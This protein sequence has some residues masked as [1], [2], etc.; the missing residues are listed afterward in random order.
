MFKPQLRE[1]PFVA[2]SE[3]ALRAELI[4]KDLDGLIRE[5]ALDKANGLTGKAV[6]HPDQVAAVHALSVVT[7]E[8]YS[9]AIDIL[10]T[11]CAGGVT[12]SAYR[13]KM[14]ESKPHAAWAGPDRRPR[15]GVRGGAGRH[16]LRRPAGRGPEP[17][18][19]HR[20]SAG[21]PGR[22]GIERAT[23]QARS[24]LATAAER[25]GQPRRTWSD[26][27]AADRLGARLVE[28]G[29]DAPIAA[30]DLLEL[31]VRRNPRRAHLLVSR[32]LGKHLPADPVLVYGSS[33]L[34]G[35]QVADALLGRDSGIAEAGGR[36]L[37]AALAGRAAAASRLV[38][39]CE[40][41]AAGA[42]AGAVVLGFAETATA[43]GHGVADSLSARYLHS[44]RRWGGGRTAAGR[45]QEEH[46]H[47]TEP[48]AAAGRSETA[49]LG[50]PAG[51][52]RRRAVH[53]PYRAEHHPGAAAGPAVPRPLPDRRPGGSALGRGP[54]SLRRA[55]R[56][57][58][59]PDRGGRI[60][61]RSA[62][63]A[64]GRAGAGELRWLPRAVRWPPRGTGRCRF[65]RLRCCEPD[66]S[67]RCCT[68]RPASARVAGT[69]SSRP[70]AARWSRPPAGWRPSSHR[71][72]D[73][74]C[75]CSASR[76]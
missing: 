74:G 11:R 38:D 76:S 52:G 30:A 9:D 40:R 33:R 48:P 63:A 53:R 4:A 15:R 25:T 44:T 64:T 22:V 27:W 56:R 50:R 57:V 20:S 14:N 19:E 13:N 3:R 72:S 61:H 43:L 2:H 41:H 71:G 49:R 16:L 18:S 23:S 10:G 32:V 65:G 68:G 7:H 66:R 46:S 73:R 24:V 29:A 45:F 60:G 39:R 58:G 5:I 54:G 31:A 42:A 17:V 51:A 47:A 35:A 69:A 75:W 26:Q 55:G 37:A 67:H 6:I 28:R 8:E 62:A 36:L 21:E 59:R 70:S 34:L 12:R 1:S